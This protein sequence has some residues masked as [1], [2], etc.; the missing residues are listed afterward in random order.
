MR[1]LIGRS[2]RSCFLVVFLFEIL[3]NPSFP[4]LAET[5]IKSGNPKTVTDFFSILPDTIISPEMLPKGKEKPLKP[6]QSRTR[7][8]VNHPNPPFAGAERIS[9]QSRPSP[10]LLGLHS[11]MR[12]RPTDGAPLAKTRRATRIRFWILDCLERANSWSLRNLFYGGEKT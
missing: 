2:L 4:A 6:H 10:A 5:A 1:N 12:S 7:K 11:L 3:L 9:P 8:K